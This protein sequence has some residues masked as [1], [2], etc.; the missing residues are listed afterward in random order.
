[1]PSL[2]LGIG[3]S[4]SPQ[5]VSLTLQIVFMLTV[6]S[7]APAILML[8]TSFT[9]IIIVLSFLRQALGTQQ[10]PPTQVITG[11]AIILTVYI[12]APVGTAMLKAAHVDQFQGGNVFSSQTV[13][14]MMEA[15]QRAKEPLRDFLKKK[16]TGKDRALFYNLALKMRH[17][18]KHFDNGLD[19]LRF[20]AMPNFYF[21]ITTTYTILRHNGVEL[22][23]SDFIGG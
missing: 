8:T 17:G 4:N 5:D 23:K 16:V 22:G 18:D 2:R 6:L 3:Q 21:H 19:Y 20:Y 13:G 14:Q 11:L 10:I 9:R 7:L 1:M 12:M 15:G